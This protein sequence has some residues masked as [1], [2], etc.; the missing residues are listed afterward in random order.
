[1]LARIG[2][3]IDFLK[4]KDI[5]FRPICLKRLL[6]SYCCLF[7]GCDRVGVGICLWV[8]QCDCAGM[9]LLFNDLSV[10][11]WYRICTASLFDVM[12]VSSFV[13]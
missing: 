11:R 5:G 4:D 13:S 10:S 7:V 8:G 12:S 9:E 3:I 1:M 6:P 2:K